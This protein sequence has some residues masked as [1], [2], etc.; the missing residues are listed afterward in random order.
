[1]KQIPKNCI[2]KF[3]ERFKIY[4][5]IIQFGASKSKME[6]IDIFFKKYK[7]LWRCEYIDNITGVI[8]TDKLI[9]YDATGTMV[10]INKH[11]NIFILTTESNIDVVRLTLSRLNKILK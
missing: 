6:E 4:P 11:Y 2:K 3:K 8:T 5:S 1:M 7:I 9:D 10:Y